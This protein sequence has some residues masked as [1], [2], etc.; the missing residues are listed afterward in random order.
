MVVSL[1]LLTGWAYKHNSLLCLL[2]NWIKHLG[3]EVPFYLFIQNINIFQGQVTVADCNVPFWGGAQFHIKICKSLNLSEKA[4]SDQ[5]W[6]RIKILRSLTSSGARHLMLQRK[7]SP[8][9]PRVQIHQI[10][11]GVGQNDPHRIGTGRLSDILHEDL[12]QM[13]R[14]ILFTL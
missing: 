3:L 7:G 4:N 11:E 12:V 13:S 8:A 9:R 1:F 14:L 2:H 10:C 6:P 5:S